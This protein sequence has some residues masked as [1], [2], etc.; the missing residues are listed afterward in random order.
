MTREFRERHRLYG[1]R[2]PAQEIEP[3]ML[4]GWQLI[5]ETCFEPSIDGALMRPPP[6]HDREA[7]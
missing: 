6:S 5:V 1:E 4:D 2:V 3:L 7:A